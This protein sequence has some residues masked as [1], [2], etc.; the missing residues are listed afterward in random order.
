MFKNLKKRVEQE[1]GENLLAAVASGAVSSIKSPLSSV[2][3]LSRESLASELGPGDRD[4]VSSVS[5]VPIPEE[6]SIEDM[7]KKIARLQTALDRQ[8]SGFDRRLKK[9]EEEADERVRQLEATW[10]AK[11]D[12]L[13][14]NMTAVLDKN[15]RLEEEWPALEARAKEGEGKQ[16][17]RFLDKLSPTLQSSSIDCYFFFEN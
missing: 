15:A 7:Q 10:Q 1:G 5:S 9:N 16:C 8:Q 4:R 13:K 2:R 17:G 14:E 6:T 3:S 12:V 11:Y